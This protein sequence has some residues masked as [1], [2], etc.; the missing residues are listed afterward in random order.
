METGRRQPEGYAFAVIGI[1]LNRQ[2]TGTR[3]VEGSMTAFSR[4][5]THLRRLRLRFPTLSLSFSLI[6]LFIHHS[7]TIKDTGRRRR[8]RQPSRH[9][10][11]RL[12]SLGS[13][14]RFFFFSFPFNYTELL[15]KSSSC[16]FMGKT[17]LFMDLKFRYG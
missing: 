17:H 10:V 4:C 11:E 14:D 2:C 12:G 16:K 7:Y 6:F 9:I 1:G 15:D 13:C 5:F 3:D 8:Q